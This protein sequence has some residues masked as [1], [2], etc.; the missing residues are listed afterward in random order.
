M[1]VTE[2]LQFVDAVVDV[3]YAE[4]DGMG[5]VY[6]ANY[7]VWM[8]VGRGAWCRERGFSYRDMETRDQLYLMVAE[9]TCRYKAPAR[10]EDSVRIRTAVAAASERVIR[11]TYE[12][13]N[14]ASG[15]LLASGESVHV[16]T[17]AQYR[18]ARMP[19][20]YRKYFNFPRR[21]RP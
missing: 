2:Q 6:Y 5:V 16:V 13:R 19:D 17:D 15:Q 8:E 12:I 9:A 10:Y 14:N 1:R 11:F 18:P 20:A 7:L 4:T 3:R 21:K